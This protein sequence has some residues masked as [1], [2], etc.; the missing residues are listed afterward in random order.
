MSAKPK[1]DPFDPEDPPDTRA[2]SVWPDT[3]RGTSEFVPTRFGHD[4]QARGAA[5]R[6]RRPLRWLLA[7]MARLAGRHA[8]DADEVAR[9]ELRELPTGLSAPFAAEAVA[10]ARALVR[11][12]PERAEAVLDDLGLLLQ[13]Q[14][15]PAAPLADEVDLAQ[16]YLGI[17]QLRYGARLQ[18][19]V[20]IDPMASGARLP[21]LALA[22]LA[23][24]AAREAV[25]ASDAGGEVTI[26]TR[27][28]AGCSVVLLS[29]TVGDEEEAARAD[30][31][32]EALE[33]VRERLRLMHGAH[34]QCE[35]WRDGDARHVRLTVPR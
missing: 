18:A 30:A 2:H 26:R 9:R 31:A 16:R 14:G 15:G 21:T 28:G 6:R 24:H 29:H 33:A 12:D 25:E 17:Q 4:A 7:A 35:A 1:P 3:L 34:A 8:P 20:E 27:A 10:A 13:A 23:A 19:A 22:E 11:A 5:S 32:L